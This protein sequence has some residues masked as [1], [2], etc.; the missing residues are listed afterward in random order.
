MLKQIYWSLL[1]LAASP[2]FGAET[3]F[4]IASRGVDIPL[5]L[6]LPEV[7]PGARVPLVMLVHGHGGSR[8]ENGGFTELAS[9]LATAGIASVR[10][11]FPGC[12]DSTEAFI[13]NNITNML[14]DIDASLEFSLAQPGIDSGRV[15]VLGYSMGGRLAMLAVDDEPAYRAVVLWA[16]VSLY[17]G[18]SMHDFFGGKAE[19]DEIRD[20]AL[21]QG[22]VQFTTSWEQE[23][24]L[25]RKFFDDL[26]R[27]QPL[28]TISRF[29]GDL[30]VLHGTADRAV[31]V[32]NGRIAS[33]AALATD[34][35]ELV[36]IDGAGHDFGFYTADPDTRALVLDRTVSFFVDKLVD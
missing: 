4:W 11:D 30:L 31:H 26:E 3:D 2:A 34:S 17:G 12:G 21:K 28:D 9:M 16:P 33:Q 20:E 23:Q 19:Y 24:Q 32:N 5:T 18:K 8:Q 15:G 25:G 27:S 6:T 7:A 22:Q 14:H 29:R 10:M 35:A 1:I 36:L 13:H